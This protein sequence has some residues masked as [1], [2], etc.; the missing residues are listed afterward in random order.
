VVTFGVI[1][2][3]SVLSTNLAPSK[4]IEY[5]LST[6]LSTEKQGHLSAKNRQIAL[7]DTALPG[8]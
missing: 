5:K 8:I 2:R 3:E 1:N 6:R 4:Q 7:N